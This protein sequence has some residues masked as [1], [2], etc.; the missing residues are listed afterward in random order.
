M[1]LRLKFNLACLLFP[2]LTLLPFWCTF[3]AVWTLLCRRWGGDIAP[4][5]DVFYL[6]LLLLAIFSYGRG[7]KFFLTEPQALARLD[8]CNHLHNALTAAALGMI[9]WPRP[10]PAP[11][12]DGFSWNLK[13]LCVPLLLSICILTLGLQLP[14]GRSP[15]WMGG[16]KEMPTSVT[17][18]ESW[19]DSLK[20]Q[21][22]IEPEALG[23]FQEQLD[24]LKNQKP[25]DWFKHSSMEAGDS[26]R[27]R[28][29]ESVQSMDQNL[30]QMEKAFDNLQ[31]LPQP[32]SPQSLQALS[33]DMQKA[34]K[35]L[36]SG[37]LPLNRETLSQLK[38]MDPSK[39]SQLSREQMEKLS[40]A[41]QKSGGA[42]KGILG[43]DAKCG[44]NLKMDAGG[45]ALCQK[46]GN[47]GITRG[48]GDAPL[49][50]DEN[51]TQLGTTRTEKLENEDLSRATLGDTMGVSQGEHKIDPSKFKGPA[52]AGLISGTGAGGEAVWRDETTPAERETLQK[53]FQ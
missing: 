28:L 17:L 12:R 25:E 35:G 10:L 23:E 52:E 5:G 19:L 16:P 31:N 4:I 38:N 21:D 53:F 3:I 6:G 26:L 46:P 33:E 1:R 9:P 48:R 44:L 13:T 11:V 8:E 51:Q 50:F 43:K 40:K 22:V 30:A 32:A 27:Q 45:M 37:R 36:E 29:F 20:E 18:A 49:F 42:C 41:F 39:L 47:G 14:T 7:R 24:Q 34:L 2:F 15:G